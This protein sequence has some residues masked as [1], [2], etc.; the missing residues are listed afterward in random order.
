[1]RLDGPNAPGRPHR[2][3]KCEHILAPPRTDIHDHITR[4]R[5]VQIEPIVLRVAEMLA[6][7]PRP[8]LP[9]RLSVARWQAEHI[10]IG[11]V[12]GTHAAHPHAVPEDLHIH[13][14]HGRARQFRRPARQRRPVLVRRGLSL[15]DPHACS[16]ASGA[17]P[18]A[19]AARR[20][21]AP[22]HS[23]GDRPRAFL[24][25]ARPFPDMLRTARRSDWPRIRAPPGGTPRPTAE[26]ARGPSTAALEPSPRVLRPAA[27]SP[28]R[29]PSAHPPWADSTPPD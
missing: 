28:P 14:G 19:C 21:A 22:S 10:R 27:G 2:A 18:A 24:A 15:S 1:M 20:K 26:N 12:I 6:R 25:T 8:A 3:R 17:A 7:L 23:A 4:P 11:K 29:A 9:I 16:L 5:L 13:T